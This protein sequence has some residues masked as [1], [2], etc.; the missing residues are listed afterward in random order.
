MKINKEKLSKYYLMGIVIFIVVAFLYGRL[1]NAPKFEKY[2]IYTIGKF[3]SFSSKGGGLY[4]IKFSFK[5]GNKINLSESNYSEN[6]FD[7]TY[8]GKR[9]IVKYVEGEEGLSSILLKYP[10][11]DSVKSAPANGWKELPEWAKNK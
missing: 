3:E 11:P 9:F 4:S 2:G 5:V 6:R 7:K 1:I 8:I 10:I